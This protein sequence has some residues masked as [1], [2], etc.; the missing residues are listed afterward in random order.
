[1]NKFIDNIWQWI[2]NTTASANWGIIN[3]FG[4]LMVYTNNNNSLYLWSLSNNLWSYNLTLTVTGTH[5]LNSI[6][7]SY[8]SNIIIVYDSITHSIYMTKYITSWT[9]LI[10]IINQEIPNIIFP[11]SLFIDN[12]YNRILI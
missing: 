8:D 10:Q 11:I 3:G 9:P 4:N 1:M 5:M 6:A 12:N 7:I 2:S